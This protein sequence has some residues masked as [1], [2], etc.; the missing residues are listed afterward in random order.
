ME[1]CRALRLSY[2][3]I[4]WYPPYDS[5]RAAISVPW[6]LS[7]EFTGIL[8]VTNTRKVYACSCFHQLNPSS[9]K[10]L[11]HNSPPDFRIEEISRF[12]FC[13]RRSVAAYCFDAWFS[14]IHNR[15][16]TFIICPQSPT[17]TIALLVPFRPPK[18]PVRLTFELAF[19][20]QHLERPGL[21]IT[22]D[23]KRSTNDGKHGSCSCAVEDWRHFWYVEV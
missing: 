19:V 23:K 6:L 14:V 21:H 11:A 4:W 12:E 2:G 10:S 13:C 17:C 18:I 20:S 7:R 3:G 16:P 22:R 8:A 15:F 5:D 1:I 9:T